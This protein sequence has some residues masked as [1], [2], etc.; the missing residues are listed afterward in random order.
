MEAGV[1]VDG[2]A[3]RRD[4]LIPPLENVGIADMFPM[5]A[6]DEPMPPLA[7][8]SHFGPALRGAGNLHIQ[9]APA[10]QQQ[11]LGSRRTT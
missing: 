5:P 1:E 8:P 6:L 7:A 9:P 11:Q 3:I 10:D 4:E 2:S